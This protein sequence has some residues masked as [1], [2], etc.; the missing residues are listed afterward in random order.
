MNEVQALIKHY[1]AVRNRLRNPPN[2]VPDTGINLR[3]GREPPVVIKTGPPPPVLPVIDWSQVVP[4]KRLDLTLS[5][6]LAFAAKEFGIPLDDLYKRT[7]CAQ[8][9]LPRQV[10]IWLACRHT[11][12]SLVAMGRYLGMDHTTILHSKRKITKKMAEN[13]TF[14]DH[15]LAL[16][17][18]LIAAYSGVT[19]PAVSEPHLGS[20]ET[21]G[22]AEVGRVSAVDNLCR[23]T[24]CDAET[25]PQKP[26]VDG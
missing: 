23:S 9:T 8:I 3:R 6:T 19:V 24:L 26:D 10:A 14:R 13:D 2:A 5:S 25:I 15:I 4:F 11:S 17:E 16:E 12:H 7:R 18:K 20:K 21:E 22:N 1:Q